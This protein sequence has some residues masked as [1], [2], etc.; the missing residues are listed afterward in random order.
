MASFKDRDGHEWQIDV[1]VSTVKRVRS[2][3][4]ID[5]MKTAEGDALGKLLTDPVE[6]VDVLYAVCQPQCEQRNVTDIQFG[7]SMAGDCIESA[8]LALLHAVIDFFPNPRDRAN[9][10]EA[11][12]RTTMLMDEARGAVE[13][14]IKSGAIEKAGRAA[15]RDFGKSSMKSAES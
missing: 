4:D 5:L 7:E 6:L 13:E 2:L 3:C 14:R 11:L 12:S 1:T 9:L 10:K 8:S 15:I